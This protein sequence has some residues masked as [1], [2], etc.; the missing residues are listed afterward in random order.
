MH[1]VSTFSMITNDSRAVKAGAIFAALP[2]VADNGC[3][4]INAAIKAGASYVL[5]P[6]G[7]PKPQADIIW[8]ES[9]DIRK[10][11]AMLC[12]QFYNAQPEHIVA[13]TGTNGKSSVV[14]FARQLWG[15]DAVSLGTIGLQGAGMDQPAALTTLD[16]AILHEILA[17]CANQGVK[18]LALEASS[19][20]LEQSRLAGV[21]IQA[22][23]FT[24][25]SH[26]HLDYHKTMAAYLQAKLR[27]FDQ[28]ERG[29]P[30]IINADL[31]QSAEIIAYAQARGL[32]VLT[33]GMQA[34]ALKIISAE[35]VFNGIEAVIA[36][37]GVRK[38]FLL[39]LLGRFQ[40]Y[41]AL[42]ALA[43]TYPDA[44]LENIDRLHKLTPVHGRMDKIEGHPKGAQVFV[45]YAH[46]PDALETVL[47]ALKPHLPKGGRLV[48]LIGCGGDRDNTKRAPM[49]RIAGALADHVI[50]TDDN[51]RGEDPALIR[52]DVLAGFPA[53]EEIGG[54]G[55][56]IKAAV[57]MLNAQDILL[58]AGKGHEQGQTIGSTVTP[59]DDSNEVIKA[60]KEA[61]I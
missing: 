49:A 26:D 25:I 10:D 48:A 28:M 2:G 60:Y 30:A 52:K 32:K 18:K 41:N 39:P 59:F 17:R 24:N 34:E 45:D 5:A 50:V 29:A 33:F 54:R 3:A 44:L 37:N 61:R 22:A 53:A 56:A 11:Y 23:A 47:K 14:S 6:L 43:L 8:Q 1:D 57:K 55:L 13:V 27:I 7:T 51:P 38:E 36:V 9:A 16:P 15:D 40:L 4:Y 58:V 31:P 12:A 35:P 42:A 21:K 19:H 20:G 46:T